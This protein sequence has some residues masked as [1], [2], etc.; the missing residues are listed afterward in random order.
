MSN[1]DH[2]GMKNHFSLSSWDAVKH[3]FKQPFGYVKS[4]NLD[5]SCSVGGSDLS[6]E[7]SMRDALLGSQGRP[8]Q[9]NW[10]SDSMDHAVLLGELA[11]YGVGQPINWFRSYPLGRG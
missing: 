10:A 7:L 5:E 11:V 9:K 2:V 6:V 8:H 3:F 1:I 4:W